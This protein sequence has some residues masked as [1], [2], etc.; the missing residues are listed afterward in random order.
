MQAKG[1]ENLLNRNQKPQGAPPASC[2]LIS[3]SLTSLPK[4]QENSS[5]VTIHSIQ[6]LVSQPN[7][8][9]HHHQTILS[10]IDHFLERHERAR[11]DLGEGSTS[12]FSSLPHCVAEIKCFVAALLIT[13]NQPIEQP[14]MVKVVQGLLKLIKVLF[15]L[16]ENRKAL[17]DQAM[18]LLVKALQHHLRQHQWRLASELCS[19]FINACHE[20]I[21]R[22][23]SMIGHQDETV[24][25]RVM[26]TLHNLSV[27]MA[28]LAPILN[29]DDCLANRLLTSLTNKANGNRES[30]D[31]DS[32]D[33]LCEM[34]LGTIQN[35]LRDSQFYEE[36]VMKDGLEIILQLLSHSETSC[37]VAA[38]SVVLSLLNGN[39]AF[40]QHRELIDTMLAEMIALGS[41]HSSLFDPAAR[42]FSLT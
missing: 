23:V 29:S 15:H 5:S 4:A 8:W 35:L 12:S 31:G 25:S 27:D 2:L 22:L 36:M 33:D 40:D 24:S 13:P 30:D 38:L 32:D 16:E 20:A 11:D 41:I 17:D 9:L 1:K 18:E 3:K 34:T 26:G 39:R 7:G 37:Q 28:S 42:L 10:S 21:P 6:Q 14:I 19:L